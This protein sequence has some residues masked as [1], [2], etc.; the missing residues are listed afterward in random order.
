MRGAS[1]RVGLMLAFMV[2]GLSQTAATVL[3]RELCCFVE[4]ACRA[5][6]SDERE[7]RRIPRRTPLWESACCCET[8][9]SHHHTP[10]SLR[11]SCL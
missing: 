8:L 2:G 11:H 9:D 10:T 7:V 1:V 4:I 3:I 5:V 6:Q